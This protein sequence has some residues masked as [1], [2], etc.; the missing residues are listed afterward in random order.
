MKQVQ[1]HS[2][3]CASD[4]VSQSLKNVIDDACKI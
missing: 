4:G 1:E 3:H 2:T